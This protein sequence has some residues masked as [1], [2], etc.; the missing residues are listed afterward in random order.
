MLCQY[1][2]ADQCRS[3]QLLDKP[4]DLQLAEKQ[5]QLISLLPSLDHAEICSPAPSV[6]M[7]FRNK[8]KMVVMGTIAEPILGIVNHQQ[9]A[10]DLTSCPLYP[11]EFKG[12]FGYITEFI[13]L[14]RLQPY[15][16][17]TKKG[18]LKFILLTRSHATGLWMLRFVMRSQ[19]C[20]AAMRKHLPV[21][22]QQLPKLKVCS[23]NL[24]PEHKAVLEG[25]IEIVLS[26]E[27]MLAEQL[28]DVPLYLQ[29]QSFF[30]TNPVLAAGLYQTAR[31]WTADLPLVQIW[32]LFCGVGGFALH[33]SQP[34][35]VV[36]GIEISE[37]AIACAS[38]SA[39]EL[40]LDNFHFQA[41]DAAAFAKAQQER[42]DLLVVNPPRR[43][44]GV[45]LC[46]TV[47]QLQPE[48]LLY[49]SCNPQSLCTD[50]ALLSQYQLRK[51]QLFDFFPHTAHA[52]VLCLLQLT[53]HVRCSTVSSP[54]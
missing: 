43:G 40:G 51:V 38:R 1:F 15:D 36:T 7:H 29:P 32:D 54:V 28:N 16:V 26:E 14:A 20:V 13:R 22:L 48:W 47:A 2:A 18:E 49:S 37:S 30:Q 34:G 42:P 5:Q 50:L 39:A 3:C 6:E 23:V 41:L 24:Q 8:A 27:S 31:D 46:A 17:A 52:E 25:E 12:A 19:N 33:L 44:L 21:L 53:A 35:R 11:E 45:E 9:Q 10:I 4:Y